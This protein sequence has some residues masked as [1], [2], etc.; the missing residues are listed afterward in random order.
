MLAKADPLRR[1][2]P[3]LGTYVEIAAD[4]PGGRGDLDAAFEAVAAVHR[5]MSFHEED[6]DLGRLRR[7]PAGTAVRV[8][9]DTAVVLRLAGEL[10]DATGGL[11]DVAMAPTLVAAGF[12]PMPEGVALADM[13]GTAADIEVLD[14]RH[15][16][17]RR[18]L[19]IDLGGIAKGHAVDRAVGVLVARGARQ[20]IVN[21][22]GDLRVFGPE[23]GTI[24]IRSQDGPVERF[25]ALRDGAL[26]SSANRDSRRET[27]GGISTPH[28]GRGRQ[29]VI[30]EGI[31]SV[32]AETC[33]VADAM[34]K[35]AVAD[36]ALAAS[37]LARYGGELLPAVPRSASA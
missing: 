17:C 19:L 28:L 18:P 8:S 37:L 3:L 2:R 14:D 23:A 31:V 30:C 33:I 16:R 25:V 34:T 13:T 20:G 29:P 35:V 24:G 27:G 26:C 9:P 1:C 12:L 5:S 10:F 21:A 7:A 15:V 32:V 6:S 11:F 36:E 4:T 22:G